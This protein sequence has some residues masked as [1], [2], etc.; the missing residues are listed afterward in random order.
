M[1]S[2]RL[3]SLVLFL[4]VLLS[5]P[6]QSLIAQSSAS[7]THSWLDPY[8]EPSARLVGE[9]L[10]SRHAW[11]RLAELGD[12]FGHRLSG[13]RALEDAIDWAVEQMK[14][15][16]LENVHKEPVKVP[17]WVRGRESLQ[18]VVPAGSTTS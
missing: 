10:A 12:T 4:S 16:G 5:G 1:H 9:A 14:K 2:R 3:L 17:H 18:I 8:R 7:R 15:D 6:S 13:S 11:E